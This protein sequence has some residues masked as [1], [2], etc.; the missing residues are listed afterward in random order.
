MKST[1][2]LPVTVS[3]D[4]TFILTFLI[5]TLPQ[6]DSA[7]KTTCA[8]PLGMCS[9]S[10]LLARWWICYRETFHRN[11]YPHSL[12]GYRVHFVLLWFTKLMNW[13]P[14]LN[15]CCLKCWVEGWKSGAKIWL[16]FSLSPQANKENNMSIML[17]YELNNQVV[18]RNKEV[19][20]PRQG[21][22]RWLKFYRVSHHLAKAA[23]M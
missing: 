16:K 1:Q 5:L 2:G 7:W 14:S 21:G 3:L 13:K 18:L 11:T 4:P 23:S 9:P 8:K 10:I 20:S 6:T 19:I 17:W 15:I 22:K 12:L